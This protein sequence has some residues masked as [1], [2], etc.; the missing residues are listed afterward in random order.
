MVAQLLTNNQQE[1]MTRQQKRD[2]DR[3]YRKAQRKLQKLVAKTNLPVT[4]DTTTVTA[5]GNFGLFEALKQTIGFADMLKKQLTV[6]RHHNCIYSAA[7]L[8][9]I[10]IDFAALGLLR[11]SHMDALK[12][13]PG[14]QKLKEIGQVPDERTL[15]YLLSH[16]TPEHIDQ[17]RQVT[18]GVLSLK[19][20]LDGPREVWLDFDDS[21]ITVFGSQ[22]GSQVGYNPRYHG[23]PSYKVKVAFISQTGEL[24]N[25]GACTGVKQA[26]MEAL[27]LFRFPPRNVIQ[28]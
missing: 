14:Y 15:R 24:V 4:F 25:A 5:Y 10:M 20:S 16:L 27:K 12:H 22:E 7:E 8:I 3:R 23:C 6:K 13:D 26:A 19:A 11:F 1:N 9:E 2:Q 21:V 17:L 18:E 28:A